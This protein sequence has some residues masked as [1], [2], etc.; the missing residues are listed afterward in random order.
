[1]LEHIFLGLGNAVAPAAILATFI[2]TAMGIT[3]G[4][5]PGLTATMGIALLI[6]MTFDLAPV[7]AFGAMLGIYVGGVYGGAITA[8]LVSTPGTAM[9]AATLMEGPQMTAKGESGKALSMTTIASTIGGLFS[10]LALMLVA[11]QLAKI[12]LSFGPP[13]YFALA[14]FGLSVVSGI[15]SGSMLKGCLSAL[16][17]LLL[18]TIGL[19]PVS[20]DIRNT[21]GIPALLTGISFVPALIGF[22]AVSQVIIRL[23]EILEGKDLNQMKGAVASAIISAKDVRDNK[24]NLFRSSAIGTFVGIIPACGAGI[25]S[26]IAYNKAKQA[27][28]TP[29]KFGTGHLEGLAATE[30]ANNAV[31]GGALVPLLTLGIPGD[32]VT[33]I[34][35]GGLM[36]QGLTPGP[37]LF[38]DYPDV[39]YGIFFSLIIANI[40]MLILGMGAV[41]LFA[42]LIQIPQGILMPIVVALCVVGSYSIN[43][44]EFDVIIMATFG[45]LGYLMEKTGFPLPPL[46]LALIL[47]P[48][49]E[50]N[51]R[52][53]MLMSNNDATIFLTR[54][55]SCII[56]LL[57]IGMVIQNILNERKRKRNIAAANGETGESHA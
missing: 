9:A 49:V 40:F 1:M 56:L 50:S 57:A 34:M 27:S 53:A 16:L 39:V 21:F 17:G 8:I 10:A 14:V 7:V 29:E 20:G 23:E 13:E 33:A 31:T 38:T 43:N 26:F 24:V 11:P 25:A 54:P 12:A 41:K 45:L 2:G 36:V 47:S 15:S 28:K 42:K 19:D 44:S 55:I 5:L 18:A 3:F 46:L 48:L 22:F 37:L 30:S 51:F 4:A 6:P 35:L 32:V 52:R